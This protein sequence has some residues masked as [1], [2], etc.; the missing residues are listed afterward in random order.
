[1]RQSAQLVSQRALTDMGFSKALAA[2]FAAG[3][4]L[5]V[6]IDPHQFLLADW[7]L[8]DSAQGAETFGRQVVAAA[9]AAGVLALKPQIA[10]FERFGSSG[11]VALERIFADARAA[12]IPI[13]ADVKR[14]D[15]GSTFTAYAAAWL[16]PG[17]PLEADA[18]TAAAYQGFGSLAGGLELAHQHDKGIFVLAATS[19]PEAAATQQAMRADKQT[20]AA[21]VLA[22]ADAENAAHYAPVGRIGVV[23]GATVQ[24]AD[25]GIDTAQPLPSNS[26]LP[27]LAPGFGAQGARLQ[28]LKRLFGELSQGVIPNESRGVLAGDPAQLTARIKAKSEEIAEVM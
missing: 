23:L 9:A 17:S 24:L 20:V 6:G 12:G 18:M 27:I 22:A 16:T 8:P 19:N 21:A 25:Y 2:G 1:M 5:C 3:Q 28:D 7:N 10:F 14:G 15:I 11:Y 13:I 4:R 26:V